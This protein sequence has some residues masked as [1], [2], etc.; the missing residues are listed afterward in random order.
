MHHKRISQQPYLLSKQLLFQLI[1][2]SWKVEFLE[3]FLVQNTYPL[4]IFFLFPLLVAIGFCIFL[5]LFFTFYHIPFE[6]W[7]IRIINIFILIC[8]LGSFLGIHKLLQRIFHLKSNIRK[9][10]FI[11]TNILFHSSKVLLHFVNTTTFCNFFII[12]TIEN[13]LSICI[14]FFRNMLLCKIG[15]ASSCL[16]IDSW[17]LTRWW[18]QVWF[19]F[20]FLY[21]VVNKIHNFNHNIK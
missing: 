16:L 12:Q 19:Q 14:S 4:L 18:G 20:L 15:L 2:S 17:I 6:L 8:F 9:N 21:Q 5:N 3:Y 11:W 10:R 7:H 13:F 1:H